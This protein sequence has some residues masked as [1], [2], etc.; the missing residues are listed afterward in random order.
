MFNNVLYMLKNEEEPILVKLNIIL[1]VQVFFFHNILN[2]NNLSDLFA[3]F[4]NFSNCIITR[5][6]LKYFSLS[7][8]KKN[9]SELNDLF[10]IIY[11][12]SY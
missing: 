2:M 10:C 7:R 1:D 9:L 6:L 3:V 5:F 4:E 8:N 11:R 12:S